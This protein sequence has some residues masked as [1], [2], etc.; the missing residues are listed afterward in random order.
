MTDYK[1]EI[2]LTTLW[3]TVVAEA[4]LAARDFPMLEDFYRRNIIQ[5]DSF[6]GALAFVLAEKLLDRDAGGAAELKDQLNQWRTFLQQQITAEPAIEEAAFCDLLCQLQSNASIK[7]H[8]TPLLHFA[9]YQALQCHRIAH[10]CWHS[11]QRAM[12]SYIQG[13]VVSLFGVDI[14]PGAKIGRG[15]FIDHAVGVVVGETAVIEDNVTL[16][17]NVT[18]GGTG[19]GSGDR[20]PKL[21]EG[22]FVGSGAV[23]FGNV[24][25]GAGAKVA[26]GAVVVNDIPAGTT[27]VGPKGRVLNNRD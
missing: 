23:I 9:S 27:V 24:E 19:K 13:R 12:A 16:F 7:D 17:Q 2:D 3:P 26:G 22:S 6:A 21:R 10:H 8:Y 20:H 1:R 25:I 14:H 18:L 15:I 5:H 11:D 4:E